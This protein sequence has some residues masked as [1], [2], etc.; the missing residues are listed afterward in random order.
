MADNNDKK[1]TSPDSSDEDQTPDEKKNKPSSTGKQSKIELEALEA[2]LKKKSEKAKGP[3]VSGLR[4]ARS[5]SEKNRKE[6]NSK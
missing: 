6:Q 4:K 3:E 5:K 1:Q 2:M